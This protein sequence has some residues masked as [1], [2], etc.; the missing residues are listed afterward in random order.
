MHVMV[1]E[2]PGC[3]IQGQRTVPPT[4]FSMNCD[5]T[6]HLQK[7]RHPTPDHARI[8]TAL[9]STPTLNG[10][11]PICTPLGLH[12]CVYVMSLKADHGGS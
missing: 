9:S 4:P 10:D 7:S 12:P 3:C 6:R 2:W 1:H 11:V 5:S 8:G